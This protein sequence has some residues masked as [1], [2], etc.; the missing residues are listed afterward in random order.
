MSSPTRILFISGEVSPFAKRTEIANLVRTLPEKLQETGDYEMRIMVPRYG[1]ISERRNRLHEV[2]RLSGSN[3]AMGDKSET[4]KVK[5]ASIPGI[6]LQVYFM[7]NNRYFKRKGIL[8]DKQGH[9]FEDNPER[10]LFFGRSALQTICNLGWSPDVVHAFGWMSALIPLL[11]RTEYAD[12]GL[13]EN[14]RI[15]YTP[16]ESTGNPVLSSE[17]VST[18][19]LSCN[20]KATDRDLNDVGSAY[21]DAIAFPSFLNPSSDGAIQFS[22]DA[23]EMTEQA[24]SLYEQ[25][26]NGILV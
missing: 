24:A 21:A 16:D 20:G 25:V 4:L 26:L 23:D 10:A 14:T 17:N 22:T 1:I 2:I 7:D 3:I 11:L 19:G 13:F 8:S 9:V 18:F 5:V 12:N 15:V 6:R